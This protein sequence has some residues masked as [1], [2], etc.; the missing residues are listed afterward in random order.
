MTAVFILSTQFFIAIFCDDVEAPDYGSVSF[1]MI[2]HWLGDRATF[3]CND[4][5]IHSG[6]LTS[7]CQ[8]AGWSSPPPKC[9]GDDYNSK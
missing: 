1:E 3:A 9:Y 2:E 7:I 8:E 4:G 6:L 5:F